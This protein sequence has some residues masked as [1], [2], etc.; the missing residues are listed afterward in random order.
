MI[1]MMPFSLQGVKGA[2]TGYGVPRENIIAV[3][4]WYPNY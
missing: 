1:A 2:L 3:Q 4:G